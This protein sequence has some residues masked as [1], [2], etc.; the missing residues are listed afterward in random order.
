MGI[1][2]GER[3][4]IFITERDIQD[5][6]RIELSKNGGLCFRCNAGEFWQGSQVYSPSCR[7]DILLDIRRVAGLPKGF[8]DLLY[9]SPHGR[10]AFIEVKKPGGAVRPDQIKF[11]ERM[12]SMGY[13]AGIAH[14]VEEAKGL[15]E[16]L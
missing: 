15:V 14:N 4:G 10:V 9:L 16:S 11:I 3:E 1:F 7:Q 6:I 13:A 5:A 2:S 8:S 12:R